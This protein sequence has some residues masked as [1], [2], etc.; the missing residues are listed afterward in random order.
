MSRDDPDR[1][2][3]IVDQL[4]GADWFMVAADFAAY[5]DS[6]ARIDRVFRDRES[7]TTRSILNVARS[8]WFSSDRTIRGYA[9]DVWSVGRFGLI[10]ERI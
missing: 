9:Q 5:A 7:W 8:G 4:R 3:A 6:Q 2:R 10:D 1:Y